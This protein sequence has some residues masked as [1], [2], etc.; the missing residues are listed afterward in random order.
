MAQAIAARDQDGLFGGSARR[1]RHFPAHNAMNKQS[2]TLLENHH[3]AKENLARTGFANR[4]QIA[5]K[6]RGNH[7]RA[8]NAQAHFAEC[9]DDFFCKPAAYFS[10]SALLNVSKHFEGG[11]KKTSGQGYSRFAS[12]RSYCTRARTLRK[13]TRIERSA[14]C[15][16]SCRKSLPVLS[17]L[18]NLCSNL[19]PRGTP[20]MPPFADVQ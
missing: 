13:R 2:P 18:K 15:T 9:A 5:R 1:R 6:D 14:S 16:A 4:Q 11:A 12:G 7:A 17:R 19:P 3:I 10:R 8:H 20:R